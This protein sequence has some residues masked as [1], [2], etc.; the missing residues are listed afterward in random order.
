MTIKER[1]VKDRNDAMRVKDAVTKCRLTTLI[2]EFDRVSK[3][4]TDDQAVAIIKKYV[5]GCKE[6]NNTEEA[7][8][9]GRYL[10]EQIDVVKTLHLFIE[11]VMPWA[12]A[13]DMGKFMLYLR[14]NFCGRYDGRAATKEYMSYFESK[15]K[16]KQHE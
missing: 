16:M 6:C 15:T 3:D 10:P 14:Q 5:E 12:S 1:V 11:D 7:D 2:G 4:P 13:N 8:L 9:V